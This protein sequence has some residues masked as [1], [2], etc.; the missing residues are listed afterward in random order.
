MFFI[1]PFSFHF[2][3]FRFTKEHLNVS[4]DTSKKNN[5]IKTHPASVTSGVKEVI[6]KIA[7]LF[8][9]QYHT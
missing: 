5:N 9:C 8:L 1:S 7:N 3:V 6:I 4:I 2:S